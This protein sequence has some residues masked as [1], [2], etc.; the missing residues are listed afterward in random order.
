MNAVS[1]VISILVGGIIAWIVVNQINNRKRNAN[2]EEQEELKGLLNSAKEEKE[3][4]N[5]LLKNQLNEIGTELAIKKDRENQLSEE[6]K[7][8][9]N[10]L[11][12]LT[13]DY[14]G[15]QKNLSEVNANLNSAKERIGKAD[16]EL[17]NLSD[18]T[19]KSIELDE[20]NK[21]LEEKLSKQKQEIEEMQKTARLE[22]EKIANKI[23]EEKTSKFTESNKLNIGALLQP[24]GRDLEK[25]QKQ[26]SET[27]ENENKQR[28]SLKEQVENLIKQTQNISDQAN[29]LTNALKGEA[30]TQGDWGEMI[31]ENILEQ[32][33]LTKNREYFVQ[34]FLK[35]ED[36]NILKNESNQKMQPDVTIAYPDDRKIIIDSKVSLTAYIRYS[37]SKNK[38]EQDQ[39]LKD[40][41][42]SIDKHIKELSEKNYQDFAKS[43]DFVMM[44]IP[45][46]PAYLL[47]LQAKPSLWHEAYNKRIVLISPTNL[48]AALKLIEDLW[49]REYQNKNAEEIA[50]RGANLY[51]KFVGFVDNLQAIGDNINKVQRSYDD[52]FKQLNTGNGN[53]IKQANELKD[54][55]IKSKKNLPTSLVEK[56]NQ[57]DGEEQKL[58]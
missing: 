7:S 22:F 31:L 38:E 21:F 50:N 17:L 24:F 29:S 55:G 14:N 16:K 15:I 10:Q 12:D 25:L 34:E 52:A 20:K 58:L 54:L 46:E 44:F 5:E 6:L 42:I 1:I 18:Y 28:F 33:G 19:K 13:N 9:T 4:Q 36:G 35:D 37:E 57:N 2:K 43:L 11:Q 53:L 40:H 51:K 41:I 39:A 32:S 49:K 30:K 27:Y 47:A 8:K 45:N 3:Q 26:I 56:A 48:I 23:F